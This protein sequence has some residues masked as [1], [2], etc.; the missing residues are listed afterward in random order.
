MENC[1]FCEIINKKAPATIIDEDDHTMTFFDVRPLF[2]GHCLIVP[3]Q[4][5]VTL[6]DISNEQLQTF[7]SKVRQVSEALPKALGAEGTFVAMNNIVSQSVPHL[8]AHVVPRTKGDGLKGFFWPR[9]GYKNEEHKQFTAKAIT[10][11]LRQW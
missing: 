7:F 4:H 5:I 11:V 9:K 2:P 1:I 8:H 10:N 6:P 3:K